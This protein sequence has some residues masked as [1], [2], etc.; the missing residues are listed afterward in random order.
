MHAGRRAC[1]VGTTADT[2]RV[3]PGRVLE[4]R[5]GRPRRLP[6]DCLNGHS[7]PFELVLIYYRCNN[8]AFHY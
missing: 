3:Y 2:G 8:E 4:E 5:S 1:L 7:W 6:E